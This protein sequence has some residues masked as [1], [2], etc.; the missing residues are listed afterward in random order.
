MSLLSNHQLFTEAFID[1]LRDAKMAAD[2]VG[3]TQQTIRE[4]RDEFGA[5][6]SPAELRKYLVQCFSALG[7]SYVQDDHTGTFTLFADEIY[8]QPLGLCLVVTGEEIG[9]MVKGAHHQARLIQLLRE[10]NLT[11]GILS[12]GK[13]WR[14]CLAKS[15]APFEIW[16]EASLEDLLDSDQL[17]EFGMF[18]RF[19]SKT[20]FSFQDETHQGLD[21]LLADSNSSMQVIERHLKNRVDEVL[22]ALCLGFVADEAGSKLG[23]AE[24]DEIYRNTIYLLYRILFLFYAEARKLL[25]IDDEAYQRIGLEGLIEI[26][27]RWQVDGTRDSDEYSLWKRLTHLCVVV[28]DGSEESHINPY[29]GG[30]FSDSEKPYLRQHKIKNDFLAPALF[31]LAFIETRD[32]VRRIDYRDLS[33]RHLGTLYEGMLEYKLNLV[34]DEPVVVRISKKKQIY[35]PQSVAGAIKRGETVLEPGRV[36]FADDKGERKSSGSYYTPEDV[37]QYIVSNTLLPKLQERT[38]GLAALVNEAKH[39]RALAVTDAQRAAAE[40]YFDRELLELVERELLS[41]KIL[42][43]AMGS[44]H[45]LVAAGQML[46]NFIIETLNALDWVSETI[47]TDPLTWKRRVVERC[48]Y[49]VD[50]NPLAQ[51]LAKL[52][53]WLTSAAEGKPLTFLDHH[54]KVGNSLYGAP[55]ARLASLPT[56]KNAPSNDDMFRLAYQKILGEVLGQLASITANDSEHIEDVKGKDKAY[57]AAQAQARRLRDV[58][59]VWLATLFDLT[60][61]DGKP[62]DEATYFT[63]LTEATRERSPE[64]WDAYVDGLPMVKQARQIAIENQFLHWELEFS[65]ALIGDKCEFDTVIANPPYV[66][67]TPTLAISKIFQTAKC[68]DLY[69][70]VFERALKVTSTRSSIGI[71]IPLSILFA[72]KLS[73]L[74][75]LLLSNPLHYKFSSYDNIP[76][77]LFNTGKTSDNTSTQNRQRTTIVI[78]QPNAEILEIE[79][80]DLLQWR[81]EERNLLFDKLPFAD[82]TKFAHTSGFPR[83]GKPEL[84]HFWMRLNQNK[85]KL[86]DLSKEI[87][88]ESRRPEANDIFLTIPRAAYHF[89]SATRGSLPRNKVLSVSFYKENDMKL[90]QALLNSNVFFWYWRAFGDGFCLNVDLLATFPLPRHESDEYIGFADQLHSV[91]KECTTFKMFRGEK[92]PSY[93]FNRRMDILLRIDNWIVRNVAPDLNLPKDIFAQYKSNSFMGSLDLSDFVKFESLEGDN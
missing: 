25:P 50:L 75:T 66:G 31:D 5:L 7:F 42:D 38:V 64:D 91:L 68:N 14:L 18:Y 87:Y 35:V 4:W 51:E 93:N 54:L 11:W 15:P 44:A 43:P 52:A 32:G 28:D 26:S 34:E 49:G 40:S 74:R 8:S 1:E 16:L 60:K 67:R 2:M 36:Y 73:S 65:D 85:Q 20:A 27:K 82:T 86:S 70:W 21:N 47:S 69:A 57:H 79:T 77:V 45:F 55:L 30:L 10:N 59:D 88:S 89:V 22:N 46:T 33:V 6:D 83:I 9:R 78:A 29:N 71:V 56:A 41:L 12:N 63:L 17:A 72:R 48:L 62:L 24:L 23:R 84:A 3:A 61:P 81:A 13:D 37:V 92:I 76:D 90:A 19:F 80:T 58:A 39:E 53:L